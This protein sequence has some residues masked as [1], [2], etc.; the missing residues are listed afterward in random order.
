MKVTQ[1]FS[2]AQKPARVGEYE[3]RC[4]WL[5]EPPIYRTYFTGLRFS[6]IGSTIPDHMFALNSCPTQ[7]E[8]RGLAEQP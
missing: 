7:F 8:W 2:C 6:S 1:W 3:F 5:E 4:T